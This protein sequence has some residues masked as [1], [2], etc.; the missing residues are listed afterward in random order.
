MRMPAIEQAI[1][2]QSPYGGVTRP[3][4]RETIPII[5][6]CTGSRRGRPGERVEDRSDDDDGRNGVEETA[7]HQEHEGDEEPGRDR[8][9]MPRGNTGENDLRNSIIGEEP[10]ERAR[11]ADA[12]QC[13][14]RE[15]SGVDQRVLQAF[16]VHLPVDK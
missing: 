2:R 7:D 9:H 11:G 8:S 13:D 1:M 15:F 10:T 12:E 14:A 6:K 5:A 16:K 4:A 3:K